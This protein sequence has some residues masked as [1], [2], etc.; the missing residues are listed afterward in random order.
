M[1]WFAQQ[2]AR[3]DGRR[4]RRRGAG[5][6]RAFG[7]ALLA[8]IEA[9]PW[10]FAGQHVRRGGRHQLPVAAAAARHRAAVAPG[11]V[12]LYETFAAGNESVGKPSRADFLLQPRRI[13]AACAGLRVVAYEDGFLAE[14]ERFV[15]RIAAVRPSRRPG[16]TAAARATAL[17]EARGGRLGRMGAFRPRAETP[18]H[19]LTGS[20]VAL[21]TPMHED[22]SVDYPALRR[23][24]D[25]HIAEGTDCIGVV[26]TTGESPTVDV[27]EHCEI[28]RVS[29]EQ[30]K[31]RV[32]DH[33]RLRRQLHQGSDRAGQVRQGRRR[34]LAAAGGALL[35]QA[36]AG[37]PVP[38]LQGDRRSGGRPADGA[39]QRARPHAWPIWR[40][41]PCCAWR[42]CPASSASR[43]PPA[44]SSAPSG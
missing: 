17:G 12:L 29:V 21:V 30:A 32:P 4:P 35:Q 25:W 41:T 11:G 43:K 15:Q 26:G 24:I 7:Q 40:T 38:A 22:G 20:I 33:G 13:A 39:V 27:E 1:R 16:Q 2:R 28:I 44:T 10:P 6:C 3:G 8:D 42:R 31:G 18:L 5:R 19:Q 9:G 23:L 34:R 36:D 14:P 37:R